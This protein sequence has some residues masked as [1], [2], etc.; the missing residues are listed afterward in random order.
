VTTRAREALPWA[1]AAV[2]AITVL[3]GFTHADP[4]RTLGLPHPPFVGNWHVLADPLLAVSVGCFA[5]AVVLGPRLLSPDVPGWAFASATAAGTLVLR[6]SLNAGRGGTEQWAHPFRLDGS[7]FEG[8]NEYLPALNALDKGPRWFLDR[9]AELVP[10]LP[11]HA[12]GHPPGLLLVMHALHLDTPA[13]LAAFCIVA[14]ALVVPAAYGLART[15]AGESQARAATLLLAFSPVSLLFG[16]TSADA[17]Y[18]LLGVLAAWGLVA[19]RRAVRVAGAIGLAVASLFAWSLLGAG[20]WAALTVLLRD[21]WRRALVL[22]ATCA[23]ALV[24][25][26]ALLYAASGFDPIGTLRATEQVYRLGI[27]H[28][29]PYWFWLTG[30]PTAFLVMA[31]LPISWAAL[32]ALARGR[33]E[34]VSIF[35]VLGLAALAGFTKAETERIWLFFAPLVCLA[36]SGILRPGRGALALLAAQAVVYQLLVNT[37][38]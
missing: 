27:A 13:R 1:A 17:F 20:A 8:P 15:L 28:T 3:V 37:I 2:A 19:H 9:F 34:A 4:A 11:V 25:F 6:L 38:W 22:C 12:A 33:P 29:R 10:A 18:A 24:A 21:G 32:R 26:Y 14:G 31:G 23:A 36:A 35:V 7:S 30:S 16:V 5:V